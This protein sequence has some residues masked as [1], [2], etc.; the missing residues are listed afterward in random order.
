M[1]RP[2][3]LRPS[4]RP[5]RGVGA[6]SPATGVDAWPRELLDRSDASRAH[7][8][9]ARSRSRSSCWRRSSP[10]RST[11]R[12]CGSTEPPER[13]NFRGPGRALRPDARARR[14]RRHRDRS[15]P[16]G[17]R[18]RHARARAAPPH[19]HAEPARRGRA[20]STTSPT[21]SPTADHVV[22]AAPATPAHAPPPRRGRVRPREAGR[23]HREHRRVARSSTRTRFRVALDDGR[24]AM[25]S[26]DT[27]DPEPLPAGHWMYAH[28]KV[29]LSAHVSWSTP[30]GFERMVTLFADNLERFLAGRAAPRRRRRRRGL[31]SARR[32]ATG[33]RTRRGRRRH[34]LRRPGPRPCVARRG[35]RPWTRSSGRDAER[36][37]PGAP[38]RLGV[39]ARVSPS[40]DD[41]LAIPGVDAVTIATPPATHAHVA[42][43]ASRERDV[44]CCARSR[45]RSTPARR[46]AML[47][48]AEHAGVT[49]LVGHEFRW[50]TDR[51][52]VG[53]ARSRTA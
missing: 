15:R 49:H 16:S 7:G 3:D 21:C 25:A 10:S 37:Q 2:P 5:R 47:D 30:R 45:S 26:L 41:A 40:L 27:V 14:A 50:A 44:T 22:L 1:A 42:I 46:S 19:R 8:A 39:A 23:P 38:T 34:R 18:V 11:S 24:V 32:P 20:R 31:L 28:P 6:A 29:R 43:A 52:T 9:R 48:A 33:A 53:R 12:T 13:W 36:T 35:L 17:A 4:R 51:A